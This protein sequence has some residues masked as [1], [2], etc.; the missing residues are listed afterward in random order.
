M[1][2]ELEALTREVRE[3]VPNDIA[4][5]VGYETIYCMHDQGEGTKQFRVRIEGMDD[6]TAGDPQTALDQAKDTIRRAGIASTMC[7]R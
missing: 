6:V 4:F 5:S 2:K 3:I 7:S 1:E